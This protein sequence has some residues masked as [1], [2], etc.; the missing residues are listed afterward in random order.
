M[1]HV[2]IEGCRGINHSVTMVNQYL[3]IELLK[4][5]GI[6]LYHKDVPFHNP[7]WNEVDNPAGFPLINTEQIKSVPAPEP[8]WYDCIYSTVGFEKRPRPLADKTITFHVTEFGVPPHPDKRLITDLFS[9]GNNVLT[10][11]SN[12]VIDKLTAVGYPAEK[13][14][15][16]PHGVNPQIFFPSSAEERTLVRRQ[17]GANPEHFIFMNIGSM[18]WCKGVDLLIRA[19]ADVRKSHSNARL[20]LKDNSDLYGI[21][22]DRILEEI[23]HTFPDL[24]TDEVRSSIVLIKSTMPLQTLRLLYGAADAYVTPYRAEGFNMT[25]LEA[26]ACGIRTIVTEGGATDDFCNNDTTLFV[27][28]YRI[29][30]EARGIGIPGFHLEPDVTH[31]IHQMNSV[32]SNSSTDKT[33][34]E[35]GRN[36]ILDNYTWEACAKKLSSLF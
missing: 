7:L 22:V 17:V 29:D 24:V 18:A 11:P 27:K 4:M 36:R 19:F 2:I 28:S 6:T 3:M 26:I 34:F 25:V 10:A 15:L 16:I 12:W 35:A 23:S 33:S 30:N 31:L 14:V 1:K 21:S 9:R 13:I 8:G 20:V 32:I 5:D